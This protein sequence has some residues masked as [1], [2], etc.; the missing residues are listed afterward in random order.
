MNNYCRY[1]S[2]VVHSIWER[3]HVT[4]RGCQT[5][6]QFDVRRARW[7]ALLWP[8][9]CGVS[10]LGK[11]SAA[12]CDGLRTKQTVAVPNPSRAPQANPQLDTGYWLSPLRLSCLLVFIQVSEVAVSRAFYVARETG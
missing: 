4:F 1:K 11:N 5:C 12:H 7:R 3:T 8:V 10:L 9:C 2:C 6:H